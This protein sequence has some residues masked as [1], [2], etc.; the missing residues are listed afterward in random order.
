MA[1]PASLPSFVITAG[2]ETLNGASGGVG[3]SGLLNAFEVDITAL[4]TKIGTGSSTATTN[5]VLAG[6]G[7]GTSAWATTLAGLTFTAPVLSGSIT[8]TYT[9]AGTPTITNPTI[10]TPTIASFANANHNHTNS[11]GGAT[12]GFTALISTIFSGQVTTYTNPGSAGGTNSFFYINLGGIK[13]FWGTTA[14]I[15]VVGAAPQSSTGAITLPASFFTTIQSVLVTP[16]VQVNTQYLYA[17]V[18]AASTTTI[19]VQLLEHNGSNGSA[20]I[21]AFV[22]GT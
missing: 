19:T 4:G 13:L 3:L 9:L 2:S 21:Y 20:P 1:F 10:T 5:A 22:V 15:A 12:L 14:S 17:N 7:A 16:G 6:T 18:Q 8:G 11:A